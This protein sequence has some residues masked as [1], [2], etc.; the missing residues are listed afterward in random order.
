MTF[1]SFVKDKK[2]CAKPS[3]TNNCFLLFDPI[4]SLAKTGDW[5]T[6]QKTDME[7]WSQLIQNSKQSTPIY[8]DTRIHQNAGA[9]IPQ[10][11]AYGISQA[12]DYLSLIEPS[13]IDEV[14]ILFHLAVGS[15]YFFEIAKIQALKTVF[16][17][18]LSIYNFRITFKIIAEPSKRNMTLQDYNNNMLRTTTA[19]MA[20]LMMMMTAFMTRHVL[21]GMA[22]AVKLNTWAWQEKPMITF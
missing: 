8:V 20:T 5:M 16:S 7:Y 10:Q 2:P 14:E 11:L 15:N 18:V 9:T 1:V 4:A 12:V 6:D 19:M 17:Q 13:S 3:G 22:C 21:Q